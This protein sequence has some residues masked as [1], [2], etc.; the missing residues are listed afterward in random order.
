MNTNFFARAPRLSTM[1]A[2]G[3][4]IVLG[5]TAETPACAQAPATTA[6]PQWTVNTQTEALTGATTID[7]DAPVLNMLGNPEKP[8]LVIR[9]KEG[10]LVTYVSWPQVLHVNFTTIFGEETMIYSRLDDQPIVTDSWRLSDD[11]TAAGMFETKMSAKFLHKLVTAHRFA[12]RLTGDTTQDAV[13][14]L[15]DIAGVATRVAQTC[16]VT[17]R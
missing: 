8:S 9:C 1:A 12:V 3:A 5:C 17:L 2:L 10:K 4:A 16:G 13:F 15:G 14:T 6:A 11:G 7:A